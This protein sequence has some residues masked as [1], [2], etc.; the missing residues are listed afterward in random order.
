MD[1]ITAYARLE[2]IWPILK[3]SQSTLE[4]LSLPFCI[5]HEEILRR[6]CALHFP[7]LRKL[8]LG[9]Q[10]PDELHKLLRPFLLL[11]SDNLISL[12][13]TYT[14]NGRRVG[15]YKFEPFFAEA[16]WMF[17]DFLPRLK[18][19]RGS[20]FSFT[21]LM[22]RNVRSIFTSL[23]E[24]DLVYGANITEE[25]ELIEHSFESKKE[26][27]R[28]EPFNLFMKLKRIRLDLYDEMN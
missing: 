16:A 3:T 7:R 15:D 19:Y 23:E 21:E 17:E 2:A 13:F 26:N 14:D 20:L 28:E 8:N 6:I 27:I 25:E 10:K 12:D 4:S 1:D 24:L 9:P 11:H 18:Y 22:D 5:V